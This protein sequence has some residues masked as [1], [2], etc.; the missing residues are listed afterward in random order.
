M[1]IFS[2]F[3]LIIS[4]LFFATGIEAGAGLKWKF[5]DWYYQGDLGIVNSGFTA[6]GGLINEFKYLCMYNMNTCTVSY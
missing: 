3:S 5:W 6:G 1:D 4:L 2:T